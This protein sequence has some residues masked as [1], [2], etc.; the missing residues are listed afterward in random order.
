MRSLQY[1]Q[2]DLS[3]LQRH[4]VDSAYKFLAWVLP[5]VSLLSFARIPFIGLKPVMVG[6]ALAALIFVLMYRLRHRVSTNAKLWVLATLSIVVATQSF[7]SFSDPSRVYVI[8]TV[9][10]IVFAC[11]APVGLSV[12]YSIFAAF[13]PAML[14]IFLPGA[15]GVLKELTGLLPL[16][17]ISLTAYLILVYV[18]NVQ[19]FQHLVRSSENEQRALR[20]DVS[21]GGLNELAI[22]E[23]IDQ[24]LSNK[25]APIIRIYL[26]HLREIAVGNN[27]YSHQQRDQ[28][29]TYLSAALTRSLPINV[30]HGRSGA[31]HFIVVAPRSDWAQTESALRSLKA[32]KIR[33]DGQA[34][35]LDPII[36]T[37][38]APSDGGRSD[39]LLDNLDRVLERAQRDKLEF[40]RFL[41]IDKALLDT[42]YLFV[43]ELRQ[44]ME[45]GDLQL[46]LQPKINFQ[47]NARIVGAEALIRWDHPGQG[48]LSPAAFLQQIENSNSRTAFAQF[49][50][51]QSSLLLEQIQQYM[52]EFELSFNLSAYD[53]QDLRVL[54]ELQ[55]VME[56]HQFAK[57]TLQ[58]EISESQTTV[59]VDL[60]QRSINA[61]RELGFS[62]SLDDFGTGMCSLSYF[63][64]LPVDAV[65]I[66]RAFLKHIETSESA[67]QVVHSLVGLCAGLK[68]T[69]LIEGIET[70]EQAKI[71]SGLG[72]HLMQGYLFGKPLGVADFVR[73]LERQMDEIQDQLL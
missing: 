7:M 35:V 44:A 65:K 29:R 28:V 16:L 40:A 10:A 26:L 9:S 52:P 27:Q 12:A 63:S 19:L 57:N 13:L 49:V 39:R 61:I 47:Q 3:Q 60:L 30:V 50:I 45:A 54:A 46:F 18:I 48:L 59:H 38:D 20:T 73:Q 4:L 53:L 11:G 8:L 6:V 23:Q 66:D 32:E 70:A 64:E 1:S 55:R 36:V 17:L 5:F 62:I 21:T 71:V 24:L 25:G 43:G 42:E 41:P 37:T 69:V 56:R 67:Q 15:D 33:I 22:R 51:R 68:R 31:G 72:C 2:S 58:I 34:I 14:I